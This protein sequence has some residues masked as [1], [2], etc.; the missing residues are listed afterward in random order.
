MKEDLLTL[1]VLGTDKTRSSETG[2]STISL[3]RTQSGPTGASDG[4]I[5][6]VV[7]GGGCATG[8]ISVSWLLLVEEEEDCDDCS[9]CCSNLA[10]LLPPLDN[11]DADSCLTIL[12]CGTTINPEYWMACECGMVCTLISCNLAVT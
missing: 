6:S 2:L 8:N 11:A 10:D 7:D 4:L 9:D 1:I 3:C 5:T 12:L